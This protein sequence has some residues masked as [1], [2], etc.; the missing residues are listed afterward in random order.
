MRGDLIEI[1]QIINGI[2]NYDRYLFSISPWTVNFLSRQISKTRSINQLDFW[3]SYK[4]ATLHWKQFFFFF[5]FLI[6]FDCYWWSSEKSN[7]KKIK[8]GDIWREFNLSC[9]RLVKCSQL[10]LIKNPK[11]IIFPFE[12]IGLQLHSKNVF[13]FSSF[14]H[15]FTVSFCNRWSKEGKIKI[16]LVIYI[17]IYISIKNWGNVIQRILFSFAWFVIILVYPVSWGCRI[18]WL[19]LC[20]RVRPPP[21]ECPDMTLNNLIV[22][23]QQRWSFG[24]CGVPLHCHCSQVH[25]GPGV[26][27]PDKGPIYGLN[28]INNILML[29]W[30]VW[31]NW[32]AWNRNVFWQLDRTCI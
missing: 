27:A 6:S 4:I 16:I 23:F 18:H 13:F 31:L 32:I 1:F 2:S 14:F 21:N 15:P 7:L 22:R 9:K 29:K 10:V 24:E 28:R 25:S 17:Y 30:I 19:H 3:R 8:V 5:F 26:V 12:E 11:S 20:R